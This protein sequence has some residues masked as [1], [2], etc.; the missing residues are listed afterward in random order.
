MSHGGEP[1]E[2]SGA[3][4][5]AALTNDELLAAC[6]L[7]FTRRSGP[8]GQHRNKVETAVIVKHLPS[9]ISAEAHEE[10]SQAENRRVAL[11]RLRLLLAVELRCTSSTDRQAHQPSSLWQSRRRGT[12]IAVASEHR[13]FPSLLAEALDALAL[14]G[15]QPADAA[16]QLAVTTSQLIALL[17]QYPPALATLNAHRAT[18]G[19]PPLK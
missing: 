13:D 8:G 18:S 9:G 1:T 5:P 11:F 15:Y 3:V 6:E 14:H 10:R 7:R 2:K 12:R 17:R 16:Q 4:H 19:K